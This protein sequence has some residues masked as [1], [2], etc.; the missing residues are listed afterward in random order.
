MVGIW[1]CGNTL[2][3]RR[4]DHLVKEEVSCYEKINTLGVIFVTQCAIEKT[5]AQ[6]TAVMPAT[7]VEKAIVHAF[8]RNSRGGQNVHFC[9]LFRCGFVTKYPLNACSIITDIPVIL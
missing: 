6:D 9:T 5:I 8:I 3:E 7:I 1:R 4:F 2:W